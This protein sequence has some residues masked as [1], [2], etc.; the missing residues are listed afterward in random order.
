MNRNSNS[1]LKQN[2]ELAEIFHHIATC[3]LYKGNENRFRAN[4]Y[5]NAA[6]ILTNLDESITVY[7]KD[8]KTLEQLKGIGESI[9]EKIMEYLQTGKIKA[10]D[11]LRN[12]VPDELLE[13]MNIDGM[14]PATVKTLHEK[15]KINN[16][17][18]LVTAL[19]NNKLT[20]LKNFGEK[21]I[22]N[23]M[24][25]L[26]INKEHKRLLLKDAMQIAREIL[27]EINKI[28]DVKKAELAGSLRRKKETIG[29][30]DIVIVSE[31]KDR[32]KIVNKFVVLPQVQKILAKGT[33]KASV[34]LKKNNVQVDIRIVN[35]EEWGAAMLYFT[36]SREHT[37]QLRTIAKEKGY[38]IN[39][40]G[41]FD[42]KN[43]KRLA[44]DTE[45]SIYKLLGLGY[46]P[47]EKR[48]GMDEIEKAST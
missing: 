2:A 44:G 47:P 38:K 28:K 22:T 21:K 34:I 3:Y 17:E 39:E 41:L 24:R 5:E 4:A 26:K 16:K 36:G 37:I 25:V 8:V 13:L 33:T 18:E 19:K 31:F 43:N 20:G 9:A 6:R 10:Y 11:K 40:Y 32:K 27:E 1:L 14:G 35:D 42:A 46:I 45:E 23:I 7:A 29:D 12:E 48:L 15:L 30:I